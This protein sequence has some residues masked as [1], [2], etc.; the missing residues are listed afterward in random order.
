MW[1]SPG[2]S[3]RGDLGV[4]WM[5]LF[6]N[7]TRADIHKRDLQ[8][9]AKILA[10]VLFDPS[11]YRIPGGCICLCAAGIHYLQRTNANNVNFFDH[12]KRENFIKLKYLHL[13]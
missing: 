4:A 11:I 5:A 13:F 8:I 6:L 7:A 12:K 3:V 1:N 9:A 10:R 2:H